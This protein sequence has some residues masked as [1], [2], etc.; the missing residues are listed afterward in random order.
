MVRSLFVLLGLFAA[1]A[2]TPEPDYRIRTLVGSGD[3]G[4]G[5][6]APLA[7]LDGPSGL[8]EDAS[9]HIYIAEQMAG[10]IRRV[11]PDGVIERFAGSGVIANGPE[12]QPALQTDLLGPGALA[13]DSDGGLLFA[14]P[15]ACRVRKI[16]TGG[17]VQNYV[18]TGR[19][20]ESAGFPFGGAASAPRRPL[21][22]D[23]GR[24]SA[25]LLD[26]SGRLLFSDE[27]SH[28]VRRLDSDGFVRTIAGTGSAGFS[29]DGGDAASATLR[30]PRGLAVDGTGHL[31][32]A[33]SGNCRLRRV[34]SDNIVET[35]AGNSTCAA[36]STN[37]PG[38]A[39]TATSLGSLNG[40]AYHAP[41]DS[42]FVTS[43]GQAR[44]LRYDIAAG[45]ISSVL[46]DGR[47]RAAESESAPERSVDQLDS[48]LVSRRGSLLI[49]DRTSF[50]VLQV[51]G[52]RVTPFAG[53]WPQRDT[54][55]LPASTPL[56][57]PRGLCP[58]PDGSLL[59]A[60]A[61]A[62]RVLAYQGP[63]RISTLAGARGPA[64]L[65]SG[66]GGPATQAHIGEPYRLACAPSGAVYLSHANLI[67]VID[68]S[69][70]L[71]T[72]IRILRTDRGASPLDRPAGLTLDPSGN[73]VFAEAG[74]HRVYKY[75]LQSSQATLLAGTGVAGFRGDGAAAVDA[76]LDTPGDVAYDPQGNLLIAD[77]G[78][79]RVRRV[80]P[81]GTIETIAGSDR[82]FSYFD[83]S[84]ELA[85]A[86]GLGRVDGLAADASGNIYI[87]EPQRVIRVNPSGR[88]TIVAGYAG[89]DDQGRRS[90]I[91]RPINGAD[92]LAVGPDG[93]LYIS[94]RE[95]GRVLLAVPA[96]LTD[97][98]VISSGAYGA[99]SALSEG[100]WIEIYASPLAPSTRT[101]RA[102]DFAGSLAPTQLDGVRVA[103]A[104]RDAFLSYVSPTQVNALVPSAIP[105]GEHELTVTSPAGVT[106][107]H[108]VRIQPPQPGL[109]A[110]ASFVAAARQYALAAIG[111][112][113]LY[114]APAGALRNLPTRPARPGEILVLYGI[115]FGP[116]TPPAE[117]GHVTAGLNALA[118]QIE[119]RIA[120]VR[121]VHE[122]AGLAPGFVGLYQ[123]NL[124]VPDVPPSE[125]APLTYTFAG[126]PG[127]Q[128]L[129]I[130]VSR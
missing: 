92:A 127:R 6:T 107:R 5:V 85:T 105:A 120:G 54:Y 129:F 31:Y 32:I 67:S 45:R 115:G 98:V 65:V 9:G 94:L 17:T 111:G 69:G 68:P 46:G 103:I 124:V 44:L 84:G 48:L 37:F 16:L 22:L 34:N 66:D 110:P 89:E 126:E 56:L 15:G 58:R 74:T 42:I 40:L 10:I 122:Y 30:S 33:D 80:S 38:G 4:D 21:S 77:R 49:S 101:W 76:R 12:G 117:V 18:G 83:I 91:G 2:Q 36:N 29:G 121:A 130:A 81:A 96:A 113:A 51:Q 78:N 63:H 79:R 57:R 50:T 82:S 26:S 104:G 8:A 90:Y 109:L 20:A 27:T 39:A 128:S 7:L 41:S 97:G 106:F 123:F 60:D 93:R 35:V 47:R 100:A 1:H 72:L 119:F 61:G 87:A 19:C 75:D 114:A 99:Y 13:V 52:E 116:V 25:L 43:P 23:I 14:D 118:S 125:A 102:T 108:T 62:E 55:P 64:G 11:R 28:V 95:E 112:A 24:V 73:L 3:R 71:R 59:L 70:A 86:V 53:Y 88:V